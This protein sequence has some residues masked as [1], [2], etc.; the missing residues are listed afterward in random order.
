[1]SLGNRE[2]HGRLSQALEQLE[3]TWYL[4]A[5]FLV[6]SAVCAILIVTFLAV[7]DNTNINNWHFYLPISAVVSTLGTVFKSTLLMAVSSALA[8]GKWTWFLKRPGTLST[9]RA[10]DAGSRDTGESF[11]LLWHVRGQ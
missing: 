3:K 6:C 2:H 9:F 8:Q 5:F 10:I 1:M 11:R 7:Y 4:E